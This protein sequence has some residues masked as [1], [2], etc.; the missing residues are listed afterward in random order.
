IIVHGTHDWICP[1][2]NAMRLAR[3]LP[4][5]ALRWIERG[6]HTASDPSIAAALRQAAADLR[7]APEA[8]RAQLSVPPIAGGASEPC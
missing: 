8:A 6:T 2:E 1:P 4:H 3:F 5:A 7:G